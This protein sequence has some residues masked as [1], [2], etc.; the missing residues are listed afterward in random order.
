LANDFAREV[1][2][3][4]GFFKQLDASQSGLSLFCAQFSNCFAV[5]G[6]LSPIESGAKSADK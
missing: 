4:K 2:V 5:S 1:F 3:F 6:M